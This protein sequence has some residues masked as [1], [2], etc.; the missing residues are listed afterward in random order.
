[1]LRTGDTETIYSGIPNDIKIQEM[2]K[3]SDSPVFDFGLRDLGGEPSL[4]DESQCDKITRSLFSM[5]DD[6]WADQRRTI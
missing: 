6:L 5:G 1:M 3:T 2:T 4:E